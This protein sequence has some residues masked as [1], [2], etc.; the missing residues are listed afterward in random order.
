MHYAIMDNDG[1]IEDFSSLEECYSSI[2]RVRSE[3]SSIK[4]DL[5]IIQI[6]DVIN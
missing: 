1:I 4:G 3:N 6:H 2:E 5:K